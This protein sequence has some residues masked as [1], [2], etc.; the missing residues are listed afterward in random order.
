MIRIPSTS[1]MYIG[2][3]CGVIVLSTVLCIALFTHSL[4]AQQAPRTADSLYDEA[5]KAIEMG[6]F[7]TAMDL[8]TELTTKY[9]ATPLLPNAKYLLAFSMIATG[10]NAQATG[11]LE[12]LKTL[13]GLEPTLKETVLI[14]LAQ[15]YT[16]QTG[17]VTDPAQRKALFE[18]AETTYTEFFKEFPESKNF[19]EDA[20]TGRGFALFFLEKLEAA[21]TD[22]ETALKDYPKSDSLLDTKYL[23]GSIKAQ[24]AVLLSQDHK[25][26][27]SN[28]KFT[29]ARKEFEYIVKD[30]SDIP[31]AN[32][33]SYQVAEIH[34]N[35]GNFAAALASYRTI[36]PKPEVLQKQQE[37]ID[38]IRKKLS[39]SVKAGPEI[40]KAISKYLNKERLKLKQ[41]ESKPDL[42]IDAAVRISR[43]LVFTQKYDEARTVIKHYSPFLSEDQNKVSMPVIVLSYASQSLIPEAEKSMDA[44]FAKYP[45]DPEGEQLLLVMGYQYIKSK[46]FEGATKMAAKAKEL[47]AAGP[48]LGEILV[49][50]ATVFLEQ[51]QPDKA[52]LVFKDYLAKNK[53]SDNAPSVQLRLAQTYIQMKKPDL[54]VVELE[55]LRKDYPKSELRA[56]AIT[57]IGRLNMEQKKFEDAIKSFK[58]ALTE[59]PPDAKGALAYYSL[60]NAYASKND[61][62]SL[63]KNAAEAVTKYP[64]EVTAQSCYKVLALFYKEKA[65]TSKLE[66]KEKFFSQMRET[67]DTI[68][69]KMPDSMLVPEAVINIGQDLERQKKYDE[70]IAQYSQAVDKFNDRP[71]AA[72][73][74]LLVARAHY[75]KTTQW[76][77]YQGETPENQKAW[78]DAMTASETAAKTLI[79]KFPT[80]SKVD[81]AIAH[82][83]MLQRT[84]ETTKLIKAD[85]IE[86][87]V[88]NLNSEFTDPEMTQK[89]KLTKAGVV[90]NNGKAQDALQMFESIKPTY[91]SEKWSGESLDAYGHA[92]RIEN[93]LDDALT[94]FNSIV[95]R[96]GNDP[97]KAP[98]GYYGRAMVYL[99]KEMWL[100]AEE[101]FN[102]LKRFPWDP[103]G[104]QSQYGM[105]LSKEKQKKYKEAIPLYDNVIKD[106]EGDN[107][108]KAKSF[109]GAG[110]SLKQE[111]KLEMAIG[112]YLKCDAY[113]GAYEEY[114]S[115]ALFNAAQIQE[116]LA[117][118][119]SDSNKAG[120][121]KFDARKNYEDLIKKYPKSPFV[122]KSKERIPLLPATAPAKPA[123]PPK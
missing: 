122:S 79:K 7:F 49:M 68:I 44:F 105:G 90:Y 100:E 30:G 118:K 58:T 120:K 32:E 106:R 82:L 54:A 34:F 23:L 67:W 81:D 57:M 85:E 21:V 48:R 11:K 17:A 51:N 71:I 93:K 50:E 3:K 110:N 121:L 87:Y 5:S 112:Y 92:L 2:R 75:L 63:V 66:E 80:N 116:Q 14:L 19:R 123:T 102:A 89:L 16:G 42:R 46:N 94:Q 95:E 1:L 33:A 13:A 43:T 18:K 86:K 73:A 25:D 20:L 26:A 62:P 74:Q 97:Y 15:A 22:V 53:Q 6:D 39:E 55:N 77:N 65:R 8:L 29:E 70:A 12:E 91:P 4:F 40:V 47:Y 78:Q 109:L 41:L 119:E 60:A 103:L 27:E 114:A 38:G 108:T 35:D 24:Q 115:E 96:F 111:G 117:T 10:D 31:Q 28:A 45:A 107:L 36:L 59:N 56:D 61:E 64:K 98:K 84:K 83:V 76:K 99:A 104:R 9:K 37:K 52:A 101:N 72:D 113:Y 69:K 88:E